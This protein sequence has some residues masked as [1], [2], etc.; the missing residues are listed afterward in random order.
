MPTCPNC[1]ARNPRE[2]TLCRSCG[3]ILDLEPTIAV[4]PKPVPAEEQAALPQVEGETSE[5][6]SGEAAE[7]T[8]EG[9]AEEAAEGEPGMSCVRC[10]AAIKPGEALVIPGRVRGSPSALCPN[11]AKEIQSRF[12]AETK[13]IQT[14]PALLFGL[15]AAVAGAAIWYL[16]YR[17]LKYDL[18]L[19]AFIGGWGIGEAVRYGA[20]RKRGKTLQWMSLGLTVLMVLGAQYAILGRANPAD[21]FPAFWQAATLN[22]FNLILYALGLFQAYSTAAPRRL[23]GVRR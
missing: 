2:N 18:T 15:A 13:D 20:G 6:T 8:P 11:C 14:V 5:A 3:A 22:R 17:Y 10:Q 7:E 16:L 9:T 21:F 1:G 19:L 12:D 23:S 4:Q